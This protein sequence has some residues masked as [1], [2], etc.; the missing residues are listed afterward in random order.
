MA[1]G[2]DRLPLRPCG[3]DSWRPA[4][5]VADGDRALP[6]AG[7]R[8]S[9]VIIGW[10]LFFPAN[11]FLSYTL[12][13]TG[14]ISR[15]LNLLGTNFAAIVGLS[16][17]SVSYCFFTILSVLNSIDRNL[18]LASGDLGASPF[19]TFVNV[20][21]PLSKAGIASAFIQAF[22]FTMGIYATVNALGAGFTL[23]HRLRI[24]SQCRC[25]RA[26]IGRWPRRWRWC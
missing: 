3:L 23:E 7:V 13:S 24:K 9:S 25:C 21:L 1:D 2:G 16:Y 22:V 10:R 12:F 5:A 14:L 26:A 15:K 8:A 11:G 17:I 18:V 19:R 4:P 20:L 6:D